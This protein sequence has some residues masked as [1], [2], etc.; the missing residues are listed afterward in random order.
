M[1]LAQLAYG[2][3][4]AAQILDVTATE[5]NALQLNEIGVWAPWAGVALYALGILLYLGPPNRF[6]PWLVVT[7]VITYAGQVG[8]NELLGSYASGFSR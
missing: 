5:L 1:R 3:L 7:L 8:A 4:I 2:I 6:L